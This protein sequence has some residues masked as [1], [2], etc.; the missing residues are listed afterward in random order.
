MGFVSVFFFY[1][2]PKKMTAV[3]YVLPDV[4]CV[5]FSPALRVQARAPAVYIGRKETEI[6][7]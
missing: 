4:I 6:S 7:I 2:R 5:F 3:N 1:D